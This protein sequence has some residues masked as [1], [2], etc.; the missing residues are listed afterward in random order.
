MEKQVIV[1]EGVQISLERFLELLE[2]EKKY[3]ELKK[4]FITE[5][6][7]KFILAKDMINNINNVARGKVK[8]ILHSEDADYSKPI[9]VR[10]AMVYDFNPYNTTINVGLFNDEQ[11]YTLVD[12]LVKERYGRE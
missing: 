10:A 3:N 5:N 9:R 12:T 11:G 6:K 4:Y 8:V 7:H 1:N 2:I